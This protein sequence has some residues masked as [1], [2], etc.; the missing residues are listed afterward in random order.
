MKVRAAPWV[1]GRGG[2]AVLKVRMQFCNLG[3]QLQEFSGEGGNS[4]SGEVVTGM[5]D[6]WREELIGSS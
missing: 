5:R 4:G 6:N 3:L 2:V 1:A